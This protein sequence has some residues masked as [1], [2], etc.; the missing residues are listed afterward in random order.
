MNNITDFSIV[1]GKV[2]PA[3]AAIYSKAIIPQMIY[4]ITQESMPVDQAM[5]WAEGQMKDVMSQM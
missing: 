2:V 5:S 3:G 4:K 1:G